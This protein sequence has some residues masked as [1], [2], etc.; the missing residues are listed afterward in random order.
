M[1]SYEQKREAQRVAEAALGISQKESRRYSLSRA[2]LALHDGKRPSGFEGEID[3]EIRRSH[4]MAERTHA[5]AI[6]PTGLALQR[7]LSAANTTSIVGTDLRAD[8]FID[9]LRN[10]L[11]SVELGARIISGLKGNVAI[12]KQTASATAYWLT[13][14]ATAITESQPSLGQLSMTPRNVGAYT[15]FSRQL[16]M[17]STPSVDSLVA[18][19]LA[20]VLAL[21]I[22]RA[23]LSGT[24]ADGQPTGLLNTAG[25]GSFT[26]TSLGASGLAEAISDVA[27]SNA[28][29]LSGG[30]LTTPAVAGLLMQRVKFAGTNSP[31]WEGNMADGSVEGFRSLTSA[32]CP[33]ATMVFGAWDE[34]LIGEWGYLELMTNPFANFTS[35]IVG[36]RAEALAG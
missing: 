2:L 15:E 17:Q 5:S 25:V 31:L 20:R 30:W 33:S 22:D 29:N 28:L 21:E 12:P 24:G 27:G 9:M 4:A 36:V 1:L 32:Q 19:D 11:V 8:Q 7:D 35:G 18:N 3:Q 23:V 10:R 26:G 16:L 6:I 13:N 34:I 14:E